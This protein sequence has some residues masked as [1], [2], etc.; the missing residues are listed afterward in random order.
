MRNAVNAN[1]VTLHAKVAHMEM[2]EANTPGKRLRYLREKAGY[3]T[4]S[5]AARAFGW[6]VSTYLG[7]ENGDR[8]V[9]VRAAK[10]YAP[11]LNGNWHWVLDGGADMPPPEQHVINFSPK[12][13]IGVLMEDIYDPAEMPAGSAEEQAVFTLIRHLKKKED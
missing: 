13:L 11:V 10:Q 5:E 9:T 6:N 8:N 12:G 2:K 4:A 3:A 1:C 7:H